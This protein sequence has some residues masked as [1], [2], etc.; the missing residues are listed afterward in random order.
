MNSYRS[1]P[2]NLTFTIEEFNA[3]YFDISTKI[4]FSNKPANL[5]AK[6]RTPYNLGRT[7]KNDSKLRVLK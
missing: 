2:E 5:I 7:W 6:V 3:E 1:E 4:D